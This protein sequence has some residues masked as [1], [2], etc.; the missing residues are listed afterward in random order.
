MKRRDFIGT[1]AAGIAMLS[2]NGLYAMQNENDPGVKA[3]QLI[4]P[5]VPFRFY[6]NRKAYMLNQML[7]IYRKYGL[8]RFLLTAPMEEIRLGGFPSPQVYREIGELV[9]EVKKHLAPHN[10]EAGWWCAP[11]LRSGFNESFQYITDLDGTVSDKSPCPLCPDFSEVFS[12]NVATVVEIA[13]PFMVQFEDDYELSWQPPSVRFGCF[14]P[15]HLEEFAKR[16][17]RNYSREE[18]MEIFRQVTPESMR[19]RRAWAELSCDS[20]VK[21]ALLIRKKIDAIASETRISLCQSGMADFDGD[22]TEALTQAFAGKTRQAVRLYG[23]SYSSDD[24]ISLPENIFHALYSRQHLPE[25]FECFH[26]SDTYPHTRFFMSAAKIRSLMTAAFAYGFDDSLFY[27]TQYLDSPTEE[28]GYLKMFRDE[29]KRF[30]TLK[31]A[32]KDCPVSGCEIIYRPFGHVVNAYKGGNPGIPQNEW[33]RVAGRFGIPYT[34]ASGDV[35][36]ISGKIAATLEE[37]EIREMLGGGLFLDGEAAYILYK[38]GW[39][40]LLGAEVAPGKEAD[41]C[42]EGVRNPDDYQ[43]MEGKLMYNLIF[44]PA[45]SEGGSFYELKTH[46]G[47]K[48][49]TDFLDPQEQPV[50]PGMIRFENRLGGRVAIMAFKLGGNRSSALFSYK[51]K[52]IVRQT[53]EWL[54]NK[55]LPVFVKDI[56]NVF[57]IFNRSLSGGHA[58]ATVISLNSDT[59][60][61]FSLD[62]A[63][64]W[65]GAKIEILEKDGQWKSANAEFENRSVTVKKGLSLMSPVILKFTV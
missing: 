48:T 16:Q 28:K 13:R 19:L 47:S 31:E 39:G 44:A 53:I 54:G 62:V 12:T 43:N 3:T 2:A 5:I 33:V 63:S 46:P 40:E 51:K 17:N 56:P 65:L 38:K 26:E 35:K 9:L 1:T 59:F 8:R 41:F 10:I 22:F 52:E 14:C 6:A 30:S 23:T 24:A 25:K 64:E 4:D 37:K 57:C 50:I 7:E 42:Y 27:A 34:A 49:I 55:P 11:S 21:L 60:D 29:V 32:V 61:S 58:V 36:L 20:L 15:Y 18:L 45:G